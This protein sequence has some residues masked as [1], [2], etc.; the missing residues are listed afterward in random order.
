MS[1]CINV[2]SDAFSCCKR[3]TELNSTHHGPFSLYLFLPLCLLFLLSFSHEGL[4][5]SPNAAADNGLDRKWAVPGV[6]GWSHTQSRHRKHSSTWIPRKY[7]TNTRLGCSHQTPTASCIQPTEPL[8]GSHAEGILYPL[9]P[10]AAPP[11]TKKNNKETQPSI[12]QYH[13]TPDNPSQLVS[14]ILGP[15]LARF[16]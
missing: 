6:E 11:E 1:C 7:S 16:R 2:F 9:W 12:T 4:A 3:I 14:I 10:I 15:K 5:C 8:D 13:H